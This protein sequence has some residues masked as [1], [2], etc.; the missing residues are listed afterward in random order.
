M[1]LNSSL[2]RLEAA[3][4]V[5]RVAGDDAAYIFKH[6]LTQESAYASML[7]TR[8][9]ELHRLVTLTYEQLYADRLDEFAALLAQHCAEAGDDVKSLDYCLRAGDV[10]ARVYANAEAITH[11]SRALEISARIGASSQEIYLKR[12]RVYELN[13]QHA[14][15]LANYE[16]MENYARQENNRAME[17]AALIARATIYAIPSPQFDTARAQALSDQALTLARAIGARAAE[18]K[19][20]WNLMLLNSRLGAEYAQALADGAQAIAIARELDLREQLAYLYN[21]ISLVYIFIGASETGATYNRQA[22]QLWLA[23]GNLPMLA[24]NRS[25]AVMMHIHLGQYDQALDAANEAWRISQEIGNMWDASFSQAWIGQ[26]HRDRGDIAQAITAMETAIDLARFG[27]QAPFAFSRADLA[28]LYGDLGQ[29]KRGIL[30]AQLACDAAAKIARVMEIFA[31]AQLAH[32]YI[33]DQNLTSA[34]TLLT[35]LRATLST[36]ELQSLYGTALFGSEAELAFAQQED[37]RAIQICD[38]LIAFLSER[39]LHYRLSD[40]FYLKGI[41][42]LR[43]KNLNPAFDALVEARKVAEELQARWI[44]WRILAAL[45]DIE[46][47]RGNRESAQTMRGQARAIVAYI[48]DHT[49]EDLRAEFLNLPNVKSIWEFDTVGSSAP[50]HS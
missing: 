23:L 31:V 34:Q 49:P 5:R 46:T 2:T 20:L 14:L 26:V 25:Y 12:G 13:A 32:L 7:K 3:Q 19:I 10:A 44:L 15:A 41:A 11:Y 17:L 16:E 22:R 30:V 39:H 27:F 8:R 9:V 36:Q 45:A 47:A 50:N 38:N 6:A 18:A 40:A 37:E 42:L 48:A 29:V 35:E 33:L 43:Q 24:D 1:F 4:L 28:A 21:D